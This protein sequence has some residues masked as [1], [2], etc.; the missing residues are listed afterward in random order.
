M[1]NSLGQNM[2]GIEDKTMLIADVVDL[3]GNL[4]GA[5]PVNS[6]MRGHCMSTIL[7]SSF[8]HAIPHCK[9]STWPRVVRVARGARRK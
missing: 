5:F 7:H 2:A 9:D 4:K 3:E 8:F 1:I 6:D